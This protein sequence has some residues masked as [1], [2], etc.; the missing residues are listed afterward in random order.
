MPNIV[1]T[2]LNAKYSCGL[3]LRY[4]MANPQTHRAR[5]SSTSTSDPWIRGSLLAQNPKIIG[6]VFTSERCACNRTGGLARASGPN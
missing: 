5:W 6:L 1:L 4:L 3:G 2:T